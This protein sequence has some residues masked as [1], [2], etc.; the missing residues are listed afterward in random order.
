MQLVDFLK[1]LIE[2]LDEVGN[3]EVYLTT[4]NETQLY[5]NAIINSI[6]S[7]DDFVLKIEGVS[8]EDIEN[9]KKRRGNYNE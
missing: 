3:C 4:K 7:E 6:I 2:T 8:E 9:F 1:V 5:N